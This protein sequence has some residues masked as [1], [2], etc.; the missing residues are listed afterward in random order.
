MPTAYSSTMFTEEVFGA[1]TRYYG[2]TYPA[3]EPV[4]RDKLGGQELEFIQTRDSFYLASV[5]S[6]GWPYVQ[7]RGGPRGFLALVEPN[8]IGFADVRGNRQLIT[9]GNLTRQDKVSLF[10]MD[11]PTR[12]RLKL[13]GT[14]KALDAREHPE[15]ADQ[16]CADP[17]LRKKVERVMLIDVKGFD[18]NCPQYITP[19]FTAAEVEEAIQPLRAR[20]AELEAALG[21][22]RG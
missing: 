2:K 20:I 7:H 8:V 5:T 16:L 14:A 13:I 9:T 12:T 18:W 4:A 10:L 6:N 21:R 11:Y 17:A 22:T 3:S 19:R 15:L 1:Q